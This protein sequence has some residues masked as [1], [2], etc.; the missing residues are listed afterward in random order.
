MLSQVRVI[1]GIRDGGRHDTLH[2]DIRHNNLQQ[3]KTQHKYT[4]HKRQSAKMTLN[5]SDTA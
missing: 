4:E 3:N 2:K 1:K 5:I